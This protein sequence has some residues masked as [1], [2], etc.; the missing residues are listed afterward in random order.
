MRR[1]SDSCNLCARKEPQEARNSL[2]LCRSTADPLSDKS[3]SGSE[4]RTNGDKPRL[5]NKH[6]PLKSAACL[7]RNNE[8]PMHENQNKVTNKQTNCEQISSNR[9]QQRPK[10]WRCLLPQEPG[11]SIAATEAAEPTRRRSCKATSG[12]QS[13][14]KFAPDLLPRHPL[15]SSLRKEVVESSSKGNADA[16]ASGE[17]IKCEVVEGR[18]ES[19]CVC[20]SRLPLLSLSSV[21]PYLMPPIRIRRT[22]YRSTRTRI[23]LN[24][25]N[26]NT[27]NRYLLVYLKISYID[28]LLL[29]LLLLLF[30]GKNEKIYLK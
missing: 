7:R 17:R 22:L 13:E 21:S 1:C 9:Q 6:K 30:S 14:D 16:M 3:K 26:F 15:E 12:D 5:H 25:Y 8:E 27:Y 19:V 24:L 29:L 2:K 11:S 28:I 23:I 4:S 18:Q 10:A 20:V